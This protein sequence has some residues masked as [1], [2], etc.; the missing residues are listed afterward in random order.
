MR[1]CVHKD[2]QAIQVDQ[3]CSAAL[4]HLDQATWVCRLQ[5][6]QC[7]MACHST[8]WR[9][10]YNY[11]LKGIPPPAAD[12]HNLLPLKWSHLAVHRLTTRTWFMVLWL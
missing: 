2:C 11:L 8:A 4:L 7:S 9:T 5:C 10:V 12:H 6:D 3:E 1:Q